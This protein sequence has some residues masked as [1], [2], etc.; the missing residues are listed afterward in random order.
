MVRALASHQRGQECWRHMW[1]EFFVG[2]HPCS[3][4]FSLSNPV[5]LP[6]Q[7]PIFP[8]EFQFD[9]ETVDERATLRKPLKFHLFIYLSI[10]HITKHPIPME[11]ANWLDWLVDWLIDCNNWK[12]C[13]SRVLLQLQHNSRLLPERKFKQGPLKLSRKSSKPLERSLLRMPMYSTSN[14]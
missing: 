11:R 3:K 14:L 12:G 7:K 9:L 1:V 2:P 8:F 10:F 6:P 4:G 13:T 5:F